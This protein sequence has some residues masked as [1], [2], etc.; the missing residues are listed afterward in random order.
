VGYKAISNWGD[1]V[2]II[3]PNLNSKTTEYFPF[4]W[5]E[6]P[7]YLAA[8]YRG[9]ITGDIYISISGPDE[10]GAEQEI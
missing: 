7:E 9:Y 8:V 1:I 6:S 2:A 4:F 3:G 10:H 5:N